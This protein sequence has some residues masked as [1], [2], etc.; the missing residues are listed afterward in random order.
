ML[1]FLVH[2]VGVAFWVWQKQYPFQYFNIYYIFSTK[3]YTYKSNINWLALSVGLKQNTR[4]IV[5]SNKSIPNSIDGLSPNYHANL[6][7]FS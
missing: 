5:D 1:A 6:I 3:D 4:T 7:Q 2:T